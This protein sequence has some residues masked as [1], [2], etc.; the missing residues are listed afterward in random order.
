MERQTMF[1]GWKNQY[2]KNDYM[3]QG[4][5]EIQYNPYQTTKGIFQKNQAKK[6]HNLYGNTKD[7]EQPKQSWER[8]ME[9]VESISSTSDYTTKSQSSGEY[10]TGTKKQKSRPM[11][12]NRKPRDKP[13]T[14]GYLIFDKGGKNIQWRKDSLFDKWC[15]DNW[16]ATCKRM[17]QNTS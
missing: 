1:L 9:L 10:G 4:N 15:Q 14:N 3:T 5:L 12:Q 16:T 17:N 11:E 8:K 6:F 7:P 13:C 2:Y